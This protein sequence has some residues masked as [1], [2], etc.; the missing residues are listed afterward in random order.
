M[1]GTRRKKLYAVFSELCKRQE[2][3]PS[4]GGF[5]FFK[6]LYVRG[7]LKQFLPTM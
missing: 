7:I 6:K 3:K 1:R 2:V 5:R 4:T